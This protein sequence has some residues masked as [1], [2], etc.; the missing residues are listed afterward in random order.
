MDES[1][2]PAPD[3]K[4][5]PAVSPLPQRKHV[6]SVPDDVLHRFNARVLDPS[7]AIQ[8]P[9]QPPVRSTVYI[10]NRLIVSGAFDDET[11]L[12]LDEAA[13]RNGLTVVDEDDRNART[14]E[15]ARRAGLGEDRLF[16][17][18]SMRLIPAG[19]G[20]AAPPDAWSVLQ[21]FRSL[22]GRED[23][24]QRH[25]A[26]DHLLTATSGPD[27]G[28]VP[29]VS[30]HGLGGVP[31]VSGHGTEGIPFVSGH[32]VGA[33]AEY[34]VPGH[35]G[36]SPVNWVGSPPHRCGDEELAGRRP[37]IAVLDTGAG[38]HPWLRAGIV[39]RNPLVLGAPIGLD[40]P[41]SNPEATGVID[42]PFEGVLDPDA[43]HG[44][45]IAGMIRQTCP[46]ANILAVRVMPSDGAVSEGVL[47][48]ALK[49]LVIRQTQAQATGDA[50]QIV[51][52]VSLSLGYYHEQPEDL[53]F[54]PQLLQPIQAL[55][56]CGVA[57]VVSA[58]NDATSRE[59][60][61]AAFAP[62]PG[63]QISAYDPTRV[64]VVSVGALNPNRTIALFS[65]AGPWVTCHRPG[66][67]L[68]STF[69]VTFDA[70][71][72]PSFRVYVPDEGWRET[73]DPD[74]FSSGFGIWSG[75]SFAAPVLAAELA[76]CLLDGDCGAIDP[77]DPSSAM[78]RIWAALHKRIGLVRR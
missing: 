69:P 74:D 77:V 62:H 53:T 52:V 55:S 36:R 66:A 16:S 17:S 50:S 15:L 4:P 10:G 70:S 41:T 64:P 56:Q 13:G 75:T 18:R 48:D 28:G 14:Q 31:F 44:T 7:T 49:R 9:G 33:S 37:V 58:G 30:G 27:I 39:Q 68:V 54:D 24:S 23:A 51:D 45:F 65:N 2:Q 21:T 72:E 57:V 29:F 32:G 60:Y 73:I 19:D 3:R 67:G 61:P 71:A 35:G 76:Q 26:L 40:D 5:A 59:M 8:V 34:G 1:D 46:D 63:G 20:P 42:D 12:T 22:V 11:R 38:S 47:L 78:D 25:V 6:L 43:G